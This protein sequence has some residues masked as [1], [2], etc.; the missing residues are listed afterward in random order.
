MGNT[1]TNAATFPTPMG[2]DKSAP[3]PATPLTERETEVLRHVADGFT[4]AE[5]AVRM[6]LSEKTIKSHVSSILTKLH[7]ADR[8]QA[9]VF[10]WR[11][12]LTGK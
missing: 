1:D 11:Q 3:D 4:N 7:L 2:A 10:A 12:G 6:S 9:A 5:I 8:T